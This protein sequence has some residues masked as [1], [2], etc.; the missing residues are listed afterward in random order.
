MKTETRS[1]AK[2]T[3]RLFETVAQSLANQ[4]PSLSN[5]P[6][7]CASLAD[8][9]RNRHC[10][11]SK[12]CWSSSTAKFAPG[13]ASGSIGDETLVGT[14]SESD[15]QPGREPCN[16]SI[17]WSSESSVSVWEAVH[18][19]E[20]HEVVEG[21]AARYGRV[22]NMVILDRSYRTFVNKA[23]T[24][25][26]LYKVVNHVAVVSGDPLCDPD[27]FGEILD[28]FKAYRKKHHW[29]LAFVG[30]SDI[31]AKY[32]RQRHW[33]TI[34]FATERVLNPIT[35]DVLSERSGKR[36]IVQHKQLL[37]PI[38]GGISLGAYMP[39]YGQDQ[40]L[41]SELVA[42]YNAW[43]QQRNQTRTPRAFITV[44]N[45]FDFPNLMLYIY[46]QAAD[47]SPNGFAALR[48]MGATQG[49]HIDP[50]I[51]APNSPK[52]ITD[53]LVFAA[54][55][56]VNQL[57]C[58]YLSL[59]C[60]PLAVLDEVTGMSPTVEK[61]VRSMHTAIFQRLPISGKKAY[62]DKFRP[63]E[64]QE[65]KLY[66]VFPSGGLAL[67]QQLVA[68]THIANISFRRLFRAKAS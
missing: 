60:E 59:G 63:D 36:M 42:M 46:T 22:S 53:L 68:V 31:L 40:R 13:S 2:P 29:R 5:A 48:W 47:G 62:H 16:G 9:Q 3:P 1:P 28:E 32:A 21:L 11:L 52:G 50:C 66:L 4:L 19:V 25:A 14:I 45:P 49:Y 15:T 51:A 44:Y 54:M 8:R 37:D 20:T 17:R 23:R 58:P 35:N 43:C 6:P 12:E 39:A 65:S 33:K 26:L 41:Q 18:G 67:L 61:L 24:A 7:C 34:H 27:L 10:L 57:G 56:L 55:A 38:K 64:D 30:A